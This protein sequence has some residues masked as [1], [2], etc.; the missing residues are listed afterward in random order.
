MTVG[1]AA[2]GVGAAAGGQV[3]AVVTGLQQQSA[4]LAAGAWA[5][6]SAP[7]ESQAARARKARA[8]MRERRRI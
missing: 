6:F 5:I 2:T 4:G 3:A 8:G 7:V 1:W